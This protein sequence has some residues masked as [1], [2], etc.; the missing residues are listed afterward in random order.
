MKRAAQTRP[1]LLASLLPVVALDV[2]LPD[3]SGG[4]PSW[5]SG[6]VTIVDAPCLGELAARS[7]TG[8]LRLCRPSLQVAPS[9]AACGLEKRIVTLPDDGPDYEAVIAE[10]CWLG[11]DRRREA[12]L[13]G[14]LPGT[15]E[16]SGSTG[17]GSA[18]LP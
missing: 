4:R 16:A 5:T 10:A 17:A 2:L 15:S 1:A 9:V 6:E 13:L 18:A 3:G 12:G 8:A 7:G 14:K 11:R